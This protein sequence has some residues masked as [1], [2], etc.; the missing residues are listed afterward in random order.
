METAR[1]YVSKVR[2]LLKLSSTDFIISDRLILRELLDVNAKI[3]SQQ[4]SQRKGLG[5]DSLFTL[6]KCLEMEKVP[7]YSCC[8]TQSDCM[9]T[10]TIKEL[11][12]IVDTYYSLAIKTVSDVSGRIQFNRLDNPTRLTN[13]LKI[14]PNKPLGTYYWIQDKH[15]YTTSPDLELISISAFFKE[16]VDPNLFSCDSNNES[17]TNPLDLEFKT[18][19]KLQEDITNITAQQI[20]N[21]YLRLPE[22]K[23]S[24]NMEGN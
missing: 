20:A 18:L 7:L 15:L 12:T 17:C 14:Y 23:G 16:L 11:P 2:T 9:I 10:R 8:T 21:T 24:D 13:L 1:S 3:I 22:Q 5:G 19:P 6:I 4:L